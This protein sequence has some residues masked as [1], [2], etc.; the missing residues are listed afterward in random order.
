M[1]GVP[2]KCP[3]TLVR[4]PSK[5]WA[6]IYYRHWTASSLSW[7]PTAKSCTFL[8]LPPCTWVWVRW[9][10]PATP[11]TSTSIISTRMRWLP[12]FP[13]IR[14]WFLL[15][16]LLQLRRREL[17][18]R[19]MGFI[20]WTATITSPQAVLRLLLLCHHPVRFLNLVDPP[21]ARVHR[22]HQQTECIWWLA[23]V[24]TCHRIIIICHTCIPCTSSTTTTHTITSISPRGQSKS[25]AASSCEWSVSWP[26]GMQASHPLDIR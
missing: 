9:S 25:N 15:S 2:N 26:R 20:T 7:L 21:W 24:T 12:F 19:P 23:M 13:S 1:P 14:T 17:F 11:S 6:R 8:R 18:H 3:R 10:S 5:S 22:I 16:Q 4:W